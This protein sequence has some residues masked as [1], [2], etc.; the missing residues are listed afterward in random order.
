MVDRM[1]RVAEL[2]K[3]EVSVILQTDIDDSLINS[4]TVT[5]IEVTRD[6]RLAKIYFVVSE[7]LEPGSD[8]SEPGSG[9][10]AKEALKGHARFIRGELSRRISLKFIPRLSFREDALEGYKRSADMIFRKLE[11]EREEESEDKKT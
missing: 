4:V 11:K 3:R 7:E 1:N 8:K 10:K 2:I 5:G 6:L 9:K